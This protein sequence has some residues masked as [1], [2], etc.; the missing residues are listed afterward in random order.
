V[1]LKKQIDPN[2]EESEIVIIARTQEEFSAIAQ[3]YHLE[4]L[5]SIEN[6]KL[7]LATNKGFEIVSIREILYLKSVKNYLDF[8]TKDGVIK[9]RSPLYFYEKKL[10]MNFIKISRNTLVNFEQIKRL[11]TDFVYGVLLY[12]GDEKLPVSRRYLANINKKL[13]EGAKK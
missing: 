4:D 1:K 7:Y 10:A 2:I 3:E 11:E 8:Y 5:S 6:E 13:E 12:I 9:V